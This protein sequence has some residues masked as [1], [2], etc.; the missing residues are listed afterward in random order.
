MP[1]RRSGTTAVPTA[2]SYGGRST[3]SSRTPSS[4]GGPFVRDLVG[5]GDIAV[6]VDAEKLSE[7]AAYGLRCRR[8]AAGEYYVGLLYS[9]GKARI[10]KIA[11][12]AG[13]GGILGEADIAAA[14]TA[15]RHH[16]R[17]ECS[18]EAGA[19]MTLRLSVDGKPAAVGTDP[20]ALG[21]SPVGIFVY[22]LDTVPAEVAFDN[23]EVKTLAAAPP[24]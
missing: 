14:G 12:Q 13:Q 23:V 6:E 16:L 1:T 24:R 21:P 4:R 15:G 3:T 5:L 11:P 8:G 20:A 19:A 9:T 2:S 18:G 22:S 17:L 10:E 7:A